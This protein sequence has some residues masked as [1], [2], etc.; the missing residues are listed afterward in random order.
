[1]TRRTFGDLTTTREQVEKATILRCVVGSSAHGLHLNDGLEDRDEMGVCLEPMPAAMGVA[2]PFEQFIYRSAAEREHRHD[3]PSIGGDLD[4]TIYSLRKFVRLA[5]GGNPTVLMVLFAPDVVADARGHQLRELAPAFASRVA[6]KKF[7]GY[8]SSQRQRMLGE[9][10]N[11]GHGRPRDELVKRFGYD[12]KFAMHMLRLS[13]QGIEYLQTGRLTMPMAEPERS[14]LFDVRQG[15][16]DQQHVLTRAGELE[17]ELKDLLETSPLP[18]DP[19]S[20]RVEDWMVRVY[21]RAWSAR[22]RLD[23]A[24]ED[25]TV[26]GLLASDGTD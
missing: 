2:A 22:R 4:L 10:G 20:E 9:R 18:K 21:F 6:G 16:Y 15:R 8:L 25:A 19:D 1:M 24:Q 7:L 17:R 11:A 12:T 3:A 23:D 5:L 13:Y 26:R 14:Y